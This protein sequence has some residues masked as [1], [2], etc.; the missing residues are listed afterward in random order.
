MS[1]SGTPEWLANQWLVAINGSGEYGSDF[2]VLVLEGES[3]QAIVERIT[4][5]E[6]GYGTSENG[7]AYVAPVAAITTFRINDTTRKAVA[8]DGLFVDM[9][10][11]H[12]PD[13]L[14]SGGE[15]QTEKRP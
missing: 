14:L 3:P 2:T 1:A 4:S 6:W 13:G 8:E 5:P 9:P 7:V 15:P 10:E 12:D 11:Y